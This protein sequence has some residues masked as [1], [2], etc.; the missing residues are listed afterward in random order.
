VQLLQLHSIRGNNGP[1]K[2]LKCIKGPVT[3][4]LPTKCIKL[5]E[6]QSLSS[7]PDRG[8]QRD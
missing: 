6:S 3:N 1:D 7:F 2:L 5:S 8:D 4:Y